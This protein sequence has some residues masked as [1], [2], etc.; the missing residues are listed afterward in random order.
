[1]NQCPTHSGRTQFWRETYRAISPC[2]AV[3][4]VANK[5]FVIDVFPLDGAEKYMSHLSRYDAARLPIAAN[6]AGREGEQS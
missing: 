5:S 1:M 3:F 6:G 4:V 2:G